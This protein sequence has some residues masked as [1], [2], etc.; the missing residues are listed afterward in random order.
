M[1]HAAS[2]LIHHFVSPKAD[3]LQQKNNRIDLSNA[4]CGGSENGQVTEKQSV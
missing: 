4:C 2:L 3:N 1:E